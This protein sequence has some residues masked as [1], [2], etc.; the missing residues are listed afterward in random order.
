[1][2][3]REREERERASA[4]REMRDAA[5]TRLHT[6]AVWPACGLCSKLTVDMLNA[7]S[8]PTLEPCSSLE[9]PLPNY[10][11]VQQASQTAVSASTWIR[12]R[13]RSRRLQLAPTRPA[14]AARGPRGPT[15]AGRIAS[16]TGPTGG[17]RTSAWRAAHGSGPATPGRR[18]PC[19]AR[20]SCSRR[21]SS[22]SRP[23]SSPS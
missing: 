16:S 17:T 12:R 22:S 8:Q 1:M 7:T 9:G 3:R 2:V 4:G 21:S 15:H 20:S 5:C 10:S 23:T 13:S 19:S 11:C 6:G 14:A 18:S